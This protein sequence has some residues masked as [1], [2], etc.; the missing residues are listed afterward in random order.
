MILKVMKKILDMIREMI[1]IIFISF[2]SFFAL[3]ILLFLIILMY[4][5]YIIEDILK[6]IYKKFSIN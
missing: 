4:I 5:Q 2:I 1:L 6:W 3:V